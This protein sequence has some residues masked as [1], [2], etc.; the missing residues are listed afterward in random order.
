MSWTTLF[1]L[2]HENMMKFEFSMNFRKTRLGS[3][4]GPAPPLKM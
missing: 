3:L 2:A 1:M 4:A